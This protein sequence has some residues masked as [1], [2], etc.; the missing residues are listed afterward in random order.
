MMNTFS[1]LQ[2]VIK[3]HKLK[4]KK[5]LGQCFLYDLNLTKK[6]AKL[7]GDLKDCHVIEIGPGPGGL[8]RALLSSGAYVSAIEYDI[9]C[10]PILEELSKA[11][12]GKLQLYFQDALKAD[13][14]SIAKGDEALFKDK[15]K[16][17]KPKIIANLPYNIGTHL[18]VNWI[19]GESWPP[20]YES[21]TLM[22]Q[23]EV[24]ERIVA[25]TGDKY[26]GRLSILV[27]W[28][29]HTKILMNLSPAAFSP[30]P[31]VWSSVVQIVP[32]DKIIPCPIKKLEFITKIAFEKRRKMLRHSLKEHIS[33]TVFGEEN[34]DPTNRP[35]NLS[36]E[37]FIKLAMKIKNFKL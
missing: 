34:I 21:L 1:S 19:N 30:P 4:A 8:T 10:K 7:S 5:S 37:D 36:I 6:I 13:Y 35:E 9:R 29:S 27:N 22:F 12:P 17:R 18:L 23:K 33:E 2:T 26:Y 20:F 3:E 28:R 14:L 15:I 32:L 31:K 24:A 11:Y 25:S 16:D